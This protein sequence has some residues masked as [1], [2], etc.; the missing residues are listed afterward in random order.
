MKNCLVTKLK[1]IVQ[2]DS[3][4]KLNEIKIKFL[5][6][7]SYDNRPTS[8]IIKICIITSEQGVKLNIIGNSYFTNIEGANNGTE[9]ILKEGENYAHICIESEFTLS[10]LNKQLITGLGNNANIPKSSPFIEVVNG[11]TPSHYPVLLTNQL[12]YLSS[13]LQYLNLKNSLL[14]GDISDFN[15]KN[16]LVCINY[17]TDIQKLISSYSWCYNKYS[18]LFGDASELIK[19]DTLEFLNVPYSRVTVKAPTNDFFWET[20]NTDKTFSFLFTPNSFNL[21]TTG[22]PKYLPT[23]LYLGEESNLP[24]SDLE[25]AN[26][27]SV[28]GNVA[29]FLN[30]LYDKYN[31]NIHTTEVVYAKFNNN[32]TGNIASFPDTTYMF[33]AVG[34]KSKYTYDVDSVS[35]SRKYILTLEG[36]YLGD[37]CDACLIDMSKKEPS[38]YHWKLIKLRGTVT[39]KSTEAREIL[40][41]KGYNIVIVNEK[42]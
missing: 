36:V 2:S 3:L 33:T 24:P 40:K 16:K 21:N 5:K 26:N 17:P 9:L 1:G 38:E 28:T 19:K 22:I 30:K 39:D 8:N 29:L 27:Y 14:V 35:S 4:L 15:H 20:H 31:G 12:R 10:I 13:D 41:S 42:L 25:V 11:K 6:V 23:V 7:D 37:D 34:S 18:E 32:L